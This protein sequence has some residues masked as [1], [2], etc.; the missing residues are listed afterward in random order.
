MAG[1]LVLNLPIVQ[2]L[3]VLHDFSKAFDSTVSFK[4]LF[5]FQSYGI[6]GLLLTWIMRFLYN[7]TQCVLLNDV[8]PHSNK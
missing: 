2:M 4:L 8:S 6:T 5:K 3:C 7:R 1:L